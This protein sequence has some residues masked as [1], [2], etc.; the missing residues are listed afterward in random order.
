MSNEIDYAKRKV[1]SNKKK[2]QILIKALYATS[3]TILLTAC[4]TT[5]PLAPKSQD[6]LHKKFDNP[7]DNQAG[8]YIYRDTFMGAL[9]LHP[10]EIDGK[11][12]GDIANGT[13]KYKTVL[14][15]KHSISSYN[16]YPVTVDM[17][18]GR[19]YYFNLKIRSSYPSVLVNR[20]PEE[21]AKNDILDC[22]LAK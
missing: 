17:E 10:I 13:Y 20:S 18:S 21:T 19:N 6:A 14:P 11:N 12:I 16:T 7:K 15:G 1:Q 2:H 5:V 3:I 4:S 22:K 9:I 8:I